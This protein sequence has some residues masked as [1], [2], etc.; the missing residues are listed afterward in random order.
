MD[1][2]KPNIKKGEEKMV[3][4]ATAIQTERFNFTGETPK[5]F[6][7]E[8][9]LSDLVSFIPG[10]GEGLVYL[11]D[12]GFENLILRIRG[13]TLQFVVIHLNN[14]DIRKSIRNVI[15]VISETDLSVMATVLTVDD[16][17]NPESSLRICGFLSHLDYANP[18][19]LKF[20]AGVPSKLEVL[21]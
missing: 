20:C 19:T 8:M 1:L 6:I 15:R 2:H 11:K 17:M 16:R 3:M 4:T 7:T 5:R 12:A 9:P 10:K 21:D 14:G 18:D 13:Q